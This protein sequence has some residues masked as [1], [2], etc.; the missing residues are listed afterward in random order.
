MVLQVRELTNEEHARVE[1]LARSRTESAR[2]VER[3][4][5]VL[6]SHEGKRVSA[7][8]RLLHVSDKVVRLWVK[9]FNANGLAGLRDEP[10]SGRPATYTAEQISLV[11]AMALTKPDALGQPFGSWTL[12]RLEVSLHEEKGLPIKRSRIDE[13]LI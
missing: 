12:D 13:I 6:S 11:I 4:R 5:I 7:I 8:A 2:L 10:R 3:A 9:R 1:Q